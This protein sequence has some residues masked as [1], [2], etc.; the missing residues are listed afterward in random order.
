[1]DRH[2]Q[3]IGT[4][5]RPPGAFQ[6]ALAALA[7]G[8]FAIVWTWP[9]AARLS[10][11]IP[12]DGAG[13]NLIFLWNFW[14]MRT[15]LAAGH[16]LFHTT[17]LFAPFGV[18]LTLHTYTP[19]ASFIGATVLGGL[20]EPAALNVTILASLALNG[21]CAYLLIWRLTRDVGAASI[22][23]LIF[24]GSPYLATHLS[25]HFNMTAVWTLPLVALAA[26]EARRG[27]A[28]WAIA[29]GALIGFTAYLDY[30]YVIY[31]LGIAG[32]VLAL[33]WRDWSLTCRGP[34]PRA[35]RLGRALVVLLLLDLA[36]IVAILTTG[37]W[38]VRIG[39]IQMSAS[40]VFNPLQVMWLLAAVWWWLRARPVLS[41]VPLV[42]GRQAA[43]AA[44]WL[45]AATAVIA[46]PVAWNA[47]ELALR[48]DY[49]TQ[50]YLWRSAPRGIDVA[51]LII[52]HPYHG[53]LGGAS[54]RVYES[55]GFH[56]VEGVGW[57]GVVPVILAGWTLRR[58]AVLV[59]SVADVVRIWT[60][61]GAV[62]LVWA[63]GPHLMIFGVNT[64]MVL[65]E[66]FLRY[67]PIANNARMPGRAL[68]VTHLAVAVLAAI[69]VSQ[70]RSRWKRP[71][72]TVF[73]L[74][75]IVMAEGLLAPAPLVPVDHPAIYEAL[76]D[77]PEPGA[78]LELPL[79]IRDGFHER[80]RFD[81]RT[82]LYQTI[83]GRPMVGGFVARLPPS[84]VAAHQQDPL[85]AFL[86]ALSGPDDAPDD[87][88]TPDR[89]LAIR[90][91][92]ALGVAFVV[93][94]RRQV[95]PQLTD[96]IDGTLQ[97][98]AVGR[99]EDRTVYRVAR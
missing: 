19:F 27:S 35:R 84:L 44:C 39:S 7:S 96:Y 60:I 29:T 77:R 28:R 13:D 30:Y 64:A 4:Q 15:A 18:D 45:V 59:R 63:L 12:G 70:W 73:L 65:P 89:A 31:A 95:S 42:D 24:A 21:F 52:G 81:Y 71:A 1:M 72:L 20:S 74:A 23:G 67:V 14:W 56:P 34:S 47:L 79:G 83:H 75:A 82:L 98:A 78:V 76:R 33:G 51:T 88:S 94:D 58:K 8:V 86:I 32:C 80:G 41:S 91:L 46:A 11:H 36:F 6:H 3:N 49:V 57:L 40:G 62:F 68:V 25:G 97:L 54:R 26:F 38:S 55:L 17:H 61:V 87:V 90:R 85:L 43:R 99:D 50:P 9:L 66:A 16:D 48:G 5:Q 2:V 93:V 37:G 92:N 10:T 22:G 53:T 69:A